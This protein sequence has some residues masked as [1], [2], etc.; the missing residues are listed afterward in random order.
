MAHLL[1]CSTIF[2]LLHH[3]LNCSFLSSLPWQNISI[4]FRVFLYV[5]IQTSFKLLWCH[6]EYFYI[7]STNTHAHTCAHTHTEREGERES[8]CLWINLL[9]QQTYALIL[10]DIAKCLQKCLINLYLLLKCRWVPS[11][12]TYSPRRVFYN[13]LTWKPIFICFEKAK[14]L[15]IISN[16]IFFLSFLY[17]KSIHFQ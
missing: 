8:K 13:P 2:L 14:H 9:D 10:V 4:G 3:T 12:H 16:Y 7:F 6:D 5:D 15:S 11:F 1:V 17:F